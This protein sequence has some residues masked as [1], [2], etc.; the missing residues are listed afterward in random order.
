LTE[1]LQF[2]NSSTSVTAQRQGS[3]FLHCP[4]LRPEDRPVT[5]PLVSWVR[6]RDWQILTNGLI[7]FTGDSRFNVLYTEGSFDWVL[8]IKRV[9]ESDY[10]TYECQVATSTGS[11]A[12]RVE[13]A[14]VYPESFIHGGEEYHVDTGSP[15]SLTCVIESVP[16]QPQFV[17]WFHN[18][19]MI[20]Y[21]KERGI[22]VAT[23]ALVG[24]TESKLSIASAGE[25]DRGNYTC[26]PSNSAPAT[27]QLFVTN[28]NSVSADPVVRKSPPMVRLTS[29]SLRSTG[30]NL[31]LHLAFSLL[32][33][34]R[35][36]WIR[37]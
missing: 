24:R 33:L 37:S 3:A 32:G 28:K 23:M 6:I 36:E 10:G 14:V 2:G 30:T 4:V 31:L 9:E 16:D 25:A 1:L 18:D 13:L 19:R 15:V 20:N 11:M 21:D 7:R 27:V 5:Y 35:T 29:T 22:Q 17:F 34:K 12:R 8:Q 26:S